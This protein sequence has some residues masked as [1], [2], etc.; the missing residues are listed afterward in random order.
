MIAPAIGSSK[1][2]LSKVATAYSAEPRSRLVQQIMTQVGRGEKCARFL[3]WGRVPTQYLPDILSLIHR[4]SFDTVALVVE[5][6]RND[7]TGE[8]DWGSV[9]L[10][11]EIALEG[12]PNS[13]WRAIITNP[14]IPSPYRVAV[15]AADVFA[16][17]QMTG[18]SEQRLPDFVARAEATQLKPLDLFALIVA[19]GR[20]FGVDPNI[21]SDSF[22]LVIDTIFAKPVAVGFHPLTRALFQTKWGKHNGLQAKVQLLADLS[23]GY[24]F[25]PLID[26]Q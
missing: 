24:P 25:L 7:E 11:H 16:L 23:E 19:A 18:I 15:A 8:I 5:Q 9:C 14:T 6:Q 22:Q 12:K 21:E 17:Q 1:R 26:R 3:S 10:L 20:G 2:M 4:L 13:R